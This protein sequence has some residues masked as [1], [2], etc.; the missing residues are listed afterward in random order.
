[1]TYQIFQVYAE[2][3]RD[4]DYVNRDTYNVSDGLYI[5]KTRLGNITTKFGKV[6]ICFEIGWPSI[7]R[8]L[9]RP[10]AVFF[11]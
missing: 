3:I 11:S 10:T 9:I 2:L 4:C 1:L 8:D 5:G 7:K 6:I